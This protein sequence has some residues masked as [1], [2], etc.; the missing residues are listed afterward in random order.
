MLYAFSLTFY[1][2]LNL[3]INTGKTFYQIAGKVK[4]FYLFCK[5]LS[6]KIFSIK[7]KF[8]IFRN[9]HL[10]FIWKFTLTII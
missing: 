3:T 5:T 6:I 10:D 1:A 9:T 8:N 4:H 7:N 2:D